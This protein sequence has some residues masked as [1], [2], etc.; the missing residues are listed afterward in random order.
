MCI[1]DSFCTLREV[2]IAELIFA[3]RGHWIK[4]FRG[5]HLGTLGTFKQDLRKEIFGFFVWAFNRY[6]FPKC[7]QLK[8]M[9]QKRIST[10]KWKSKE[11][12]NVF[13]GFI[14]W[15]QVLYLLLELIF[16]INTENAKILLSLHEVL[17]SSD[18]FTNL[19]TVCI[20]IFFCG[21]NKVVNFECLV[22]IILIV[23]RKLL[24]CLIDF[25]AFLLF[26]FCIL[27]IW[28][29]YIRSTC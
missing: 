28:W 3:L 14:F 17:F 7:K 22:F 19:F 9:T 2:I 29:M 21:E 16:A 15:A 12:K 11:K 27:V 8:I 24:I 20:Y 6:F 1:R 13:A 10:L 18:I 23:W 5:T 26:T 4:I 25:W